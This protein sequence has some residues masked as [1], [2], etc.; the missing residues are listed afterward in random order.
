MDIESLAAGALGSIDS[1]LRLVAAT[2]ICS[3]LSGLLSFDYDATPSFPPPSA[4]VLVMC[5]AD[6]VSLRSSGLGLMASVSR[7]VAGTVDKDFVVSHDLLRPRVLV[8]ALLARL[9]FN[10]EVRT[11]FVAHSVRSC[12]SGLFPLSM[13]LC[14]DCIGEER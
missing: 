10:V 7:L 6:T 9:A 3:I 12:P 14:N 4:V 11:F 5:I 8:V 1:A 2:S 13:S